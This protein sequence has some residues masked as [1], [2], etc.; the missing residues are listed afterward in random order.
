MAFSK[1]RLTEA[2][3]EALKPLLQAHRDEVTVLL[4]VPLDPDW[5]TYHTLDD[6][7]ILHVFTARHGG[8]LV[9]YAIYTVS[10]HLHY[11]ILCAMQDVLYLSPEYRRGMWAK[12]LI[13]FSEK[14]LAASGVDVVT[15]HS[16][17]HKDLSALLTFMEYQPMDTIWYKRLR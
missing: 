17:K 1:E 8:E 12:Q 5:P 2:V 7:G 14:A 15:Q 9:G 4:D 10:R 11:P 13:G 3:V 6:A 16:K